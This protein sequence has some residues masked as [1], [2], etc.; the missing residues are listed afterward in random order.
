M[1]SRC[2]IERIGTGASIPTSD[3]PMVH[4]P[5][6][7][8]ILGM[9]LREVILDDSDLLRG[10]EYVEVDECVEQE[11]NERCNSDFS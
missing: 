11:G 9:D 1:E 10:S 4:F 6:I 3:A 5:N 2:R 7:K 8:I